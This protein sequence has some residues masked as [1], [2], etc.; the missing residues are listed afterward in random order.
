MNKALPL[1]LGLLALAAPAQAETRNFRA[2]YAVSLYGIPIAR[3]RFESVIGE[4]SFKVAGSLSSAGLAKVFDDTKGTTRASGRF[5]ETQAQPDAYVVN[6]TSGKK[7]KK[8]AISFAGGDVT[9][10]ENVPPPKKRSRKWVEVDENDLKS[11]ADPISAT[12]VPASGLDDVCNRTLKI[13]DGELRADIRLSHVET[14]PVRTNG[15]QGE[16]VTCSARFVPVSGYRKG[17]D[18]LEY[19]ANRSKILIAF[20][21]LGDTGVYAPVKASVGTEIGTVHIEVQRFE[22]Q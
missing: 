22:S 16:A 11:V 13:Y 1:L 5:S 12:L 19:L 20:A 7:K 4:D 17:S 18:S 15:Y 10:T 9:A 8:T 2:D 3:S 21:P 6:Y 14:R